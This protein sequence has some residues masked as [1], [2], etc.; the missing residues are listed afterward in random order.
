LNYLKSL[1]IDI[2]KIDKSFLRDMNNDSK[3]KAILKTIILLARQLGITVLAEGIETEEQLNFLKKHHCHT[4]QGFF[5]SAPVPSSQLITEIEDV[6][7]LV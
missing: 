6:E 3:S 5:F 1:P 4:A 2:L 7:L